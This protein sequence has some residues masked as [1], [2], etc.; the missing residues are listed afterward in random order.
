MIRNQYIPSLLTLLLL[1]LWIPAALDKI[2]DLEGF[3]RTLLQQPIPDRWAGILYWL[4]PVV[5]FVCAVLL[6]GGAV[7]SPKTHRL[8][9]GGFALSALLMLA[10]TAFILLGVLGWYQ[11]RPCGCGSVITGLS[12]EQHLWFNVAFLLISMAGW[13][14]SR[15]AGNS[16]DGSGR[17]PS[18][19]PSRQRRGALVFST[20][21]LLTRASRIVP[22]C[23]AYGRFR[24][25]RRFALFP[26]RP[27]ILSFQIPLSPRT[28]R[29]R[30][31]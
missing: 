26:G 7:N 25:P 16:G 17:K 12:W 22:G 30:S 29:V 5:E 2:Q 31:C 14:L 10:F 13:L 20:G 3:H 21:V 28:V 1:L 8:R 23:S 6:V 19:D 15:R 24:Y 18:R 27:E 9:T 4:L 11:K